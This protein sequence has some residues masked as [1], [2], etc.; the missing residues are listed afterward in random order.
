M[1]GI[2]TWSCTRSHH[3][4]G[5]SYVSHRQTSWWHV[6]WK[7]V[8][9]LQHF[10]IGRSSQWSTETLFFPLLHNNCWIP[11]GN[12]THTENPCKILYRALPAWIHIH[13]P[14]VSFK[15]RLQRKKK[16]KVNVHSILSIKLIPLCLFVLIKENLKYFF[17]S[18]YQLYIQDEGVAF[19]LSLPRNNELLRFF[20]W[21]VFCLVVFWGFCLFVF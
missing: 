8:Q 2:G 15:T 17:Y 20:S 6:Y 9:N 16:K 1:R 19:L 10:M 14:L 18:E 3:N 21:V 7:S 4:R 12:E 11:P 13:M 5:H